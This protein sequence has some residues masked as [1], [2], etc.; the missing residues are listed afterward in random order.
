[1]VRALADCLRAHSA[2]WV[3]PDHAWMPPP[4]AV[5]GQLDAVTGPFAYLR[6]LGDRDEVDRRTPSL[7]RVVVD[8]SEQILR[9]AEVIRLLSERVPVLAF[10]NNHYAG[11]ATATVQDLRGALGL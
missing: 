6:L 2:V 11:Y 5:V 8:R 3:L 7:D 4:L 9:D 10:V 1:M